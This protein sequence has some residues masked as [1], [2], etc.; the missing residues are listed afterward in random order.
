MLFI[1]PTLD[2]HELQVIASIDE[3]R[4]RLRFMLR[5]PRRWYGP[6]R[7]TTFA[8]NVQASNSIEGHNVSLDDAAAAI[9]GGEPLEASDEDW[10]AVNN[11]CDAMTYIIQ[12]ADDTHFKYNEALVRSLHF[13]MMRHDWAAMP[14][15]YRPGAVFVWSTGE[16]EVVYE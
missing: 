2:D 13:M 15:L 6:L 14:G 3:T 5:E 11:Y 10:N 16:G 1:A 4:E 7:R 8:R 9:D 12:L